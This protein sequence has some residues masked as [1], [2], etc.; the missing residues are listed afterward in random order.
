MQSSQLGHSLVLCAVDCGCT[1]ITF[2]QHIYGQVRDNITACVRVQTRLTISSS[3]G[4][5]DPISCGL[6]FQKADG[7]CELI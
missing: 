6:L 2:D 3:K 5:T 7:D 1:T 4:L